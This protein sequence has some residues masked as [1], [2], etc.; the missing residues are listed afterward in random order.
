MCVKTFKT[1]P[2]DSQVP[3]R[4]HVGLQDTC[5]VL[6]SYTVHCVF[7]QISIVTKHNI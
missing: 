1:G 6:I 7:I 2:K 4:L 3:H 5:A